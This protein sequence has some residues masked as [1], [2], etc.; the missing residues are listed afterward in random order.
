LLISAVKSARVHNAKTNNYLT[1][2]VRVSRVDYSVNVI[3][4][5][6]VF[7]DAK[8]TLNARI[9]L[10]VGADFELETEF[11]G[12]TGKIVKRPSRSRI[13]ACVILNIA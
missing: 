3:S 10:F 8:L 12:E 9:H 7:D 4:A 11:I 13:T 1:L 6:K 5:T 2:A